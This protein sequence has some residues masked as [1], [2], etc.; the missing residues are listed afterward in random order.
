M[1]E[2]VPEI[3]APRSTIPL[4]TKNGVKSAA[5]QIS[6]GFVWAWKIHNTPKCCVPAANALSVRLKVLAFPVYPIQ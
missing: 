1:L 3:D 4:H 6:Q 5:L 2:T